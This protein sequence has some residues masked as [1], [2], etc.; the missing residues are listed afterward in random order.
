MSVVYSKP[1]KEA[2]AAKPKGT[3]EANAGDVV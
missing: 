3:K 2:T 1:S